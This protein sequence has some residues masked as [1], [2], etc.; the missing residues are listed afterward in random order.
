MRAGQ[1]AGCCTWLYGLFVPKPSCGAGRQRRMRGLRQ[2]VCACPLAFT[3]V[4]G[5]CHHLSSVAFP[6]LG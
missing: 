6:C 3:A 4:G 2:T 5:D 1:V